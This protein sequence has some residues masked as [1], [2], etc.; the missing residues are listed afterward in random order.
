MAAGERLIPPLDL[1]RRRAEVREILFSLPPELSELTP[2]E[3]P[4]YPVQISPEVQA[5]M[6]ARR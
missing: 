1:A 5:L 2:V 6:A 4:T 3:N